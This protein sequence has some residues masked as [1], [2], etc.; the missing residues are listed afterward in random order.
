[1]RFNGRAIEAYAG[2]TVAS[3]LLA[4]GIHLV[5]RSFKYH[6]PRGVFSHGAEEPN[7]LFAVDRGGDRIDPNNRASSVEAVDAL[8]VRSQ[9]HWPSLG[10]DVGALGD[11]LSPLLVAGFYYK[12]FMWPR[13]FW[14]RLYEPWIRAA[15]GFGRA[16]SAR[17]IPT[18]TSICTRTAT[19]WWSAA[20]RP[21]LPRHWQPSEGGKRVILADE[22]AEMG[23][24]LLHDRTSSID[25]KPAWAW[26][27]DALASLG[28]ARE[29][30]LAAAYDRLRLLQ[31]QPTSAWC[32]G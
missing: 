11:V 22:Q 31:S 32:S 12:T 28:A 18:V 10:F 17:R 20:A 25:G 16:P 8:S 3:A 24:A 30:H 27:A 13:S 19:C 6:R 9:N 7:A 5:G 26:L 23:G 2:D 4:N 1:M 29:R 15:A 21:V 14:S